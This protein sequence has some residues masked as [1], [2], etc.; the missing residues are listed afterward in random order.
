MNPLNLTKTR[1]LEYRLSVRLP[2]FNIWFKIMP[3]LYKYEYDIGLYIINIISREYNASN[4]MLSA[5][6]CILL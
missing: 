6:V 2:S 5:E 4:I 1:L 3:L